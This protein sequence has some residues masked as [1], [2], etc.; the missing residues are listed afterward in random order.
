MPLVIVCSRSPMPG[1]WHM[2][3]PLFKLGHA[4]YRGSVSLVQ[5]MRPEPRSLVSTSSTDARALW[6]RV[7]RAKDTL[8]LP[9]A[10]CETGT[11]W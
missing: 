10:A 4:I 11:L 2:D 6:R 5:K 8:S 7:S 9:S 3:W 1:P